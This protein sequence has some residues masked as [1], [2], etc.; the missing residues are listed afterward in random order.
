MCTVHTFCVWLPAYGLFVISALRPNH[1]EDL[2]LKVSFITFHHRMSFFTMDSIRKVHTPS[3]SDPDMEVVITHFMTSYLAYVHPPG[4]V[5]RLLQWTAP[6]SD[7]SALLPIQIHFPCHISSLAHRGS[8]VAD[9]RPTPNSMENPGHYAGLFGHV[10]ALVYPDR[11]YLD[12]NAEVSL[13][14]P[15]QVMLLQA[16]PATAPAVTVSPDIYGTR[17]EPF[18]LS[19]HDLLLIPGKHEQ[20]TSQGTPPSTCL[21]YDISPPIQATIPMVI[22]PASGRTAFKLPDGRAQ[23][24][25]VR[26]HFTKCLHDPSAR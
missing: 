8:T 9:F 12:P 25:T 20:G 13:Y 3:L 7:T 15:Q 22:T 21:L 19:Y 26:A 18:S 2:S 10:T 1:P 14:H 5:H 6:P 16:T 24:A 11:V 23:W 4:Y 17:G